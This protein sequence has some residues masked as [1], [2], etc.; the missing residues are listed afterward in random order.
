[1]YDGIANNDLRSKNGTIINNN[2]SLEQIHKNFGV[3]WAI[4]PSSSLF[5]YESDQSAKFF[6]EKNREFIPSFIDPIKEDNSSIRTNCK[7]NATSSSSSWNQAQ[8]ACYYDLYMTNDI[9]FGQ[10]SLIGVNEILS[11]RMNQRNPPSF[12]SLLPLTMNLI[13]GE[14]VYLNVSATSEYLVHVVALTDLHRP[15]N[16]TFNQ[17]TG[18]FQW[19]AIKGE[20]YLS[21]EALDKIYNLKSKHDIIFY[22]KVSDDETTVASGNGNNNQV[23]EVNFIILII[24]LNFLFYR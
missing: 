21:V 9:N 19:T 4:D 18:I 11:I 6:A 24:V 14:Q 23:N 20:H 17:N 22:V 5:Y 12:N 16:A 15:E 8:R 2:A 13:H 1:T 3:T 7:I 10:A